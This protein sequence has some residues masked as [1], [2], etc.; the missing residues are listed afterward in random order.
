MNYSVKG[1]TPLRYW[2]LIFG[3]WALVCPQ[4]QSQESPAADPRLVRAYQQC[5][6]SRQYPPE[7]VKEIQD[8]LKNATRATEAL[9]ELAKD[10]RREIRLLVVLL[11]GELGEKDGANLLWKL[12]QDGA[13]AVR[14]AASGALV[15]LHETVPVPPDVSA[16]RDTRPEV[17][18]LAVATLGKIGDKNVVPLLLGALEDENE[19][20]RQEAIRAVADRPPQEAAGKALLKR[21]HDPNVEVRTAAVSALRAHLTPQ[22]IQELEAALKDP[23]W[24]VRAATILA[25]G[26]RDNPIL[27]EPDVVQAIVMALQSDEFALVRDRAA[28]ALRFV[29]PKLVAQSLVEVLISTNRAVRF[30]AVRSICHSRI[31]DTLPLLMEHT[32]HPDADVRE[33]IMDVFGAIGGANQVPKILET[34]DDAEPRVR[35]AAVRA[36]SQLAPRENGA[37]L[38]QRLS[39]AD[40]HVR[41][42]AARGLG[43]AG[44]KTQVPK[45][46]PLLRDNLGYVRAAA[47]EALGKLGDRAAVGPL[48]ELFTGQSSDGSGLGL[49]VDPGRGSET[50]RLEITVSEQRA[51]VARALG[52]LRP[53]DAVDALIKHGLQSKDANLQRISAHALGKIGDR[54]AVE[55]LME[56]VRPYYETVKSAPLEEGLIIA[57]GKSPAT[58]PVRADVVKQ[59]LVRAEIAWALGQIGDPVAEPLLRRALDDPNSLV[60][61][62]AAEALAKIAERRER[63]SALAQSARVAVTAPTATA[64]DKSRS[65]NAARTP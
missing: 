59:A 54:R 35:L 27:S 2:I 13:E 45:L 37:A 18:R 22:V 14:V 50:N 17:R 16:L 10:P 31:T 32:K 64:P 34:L 62:A 44:D 41:A 63:E 65:G 26:R 51:I 38:A 47:A 49:V 25:L 6:F 24:H 33:H 30:H 48:L 28:D 23:D 52:E 11:L 53:P 12:L 19:M 9:S 58:D 3:W 1:T 4:A 60:R 15:S 20:V 5:H 56:S 55:P 46:I 39:D 8:K 57:D 29:N 43:L 7:A 42:A 36:L 40:P 21:L 61:D